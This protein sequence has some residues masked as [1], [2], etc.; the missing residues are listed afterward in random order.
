MKWPRKI[1]ELKFYNNGVS[2]EQASNES[3]KMAAII[4]ILMKPRTNKNQ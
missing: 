1:T 3:M 2:S 4:N